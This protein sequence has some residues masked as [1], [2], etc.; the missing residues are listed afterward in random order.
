MNL[1]QTAVKIYLKKISYMMSGMWFSQTY[2]PSPIIKIL[3]NMEW[4]HFWHGVS[5]K[6][7]TWSKILQSSDW[8]RRYNIPVTYTSVSPNW[9]VD[10]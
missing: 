7:Y 1:C 10:F 9:N 4:N 6:M 2:L 5:S 8:N 3:V